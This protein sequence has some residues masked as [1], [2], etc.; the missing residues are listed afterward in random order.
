MISGIGR[1]GGPGGPRTPPICQTDYFFISKRN[2]GLLL[3]QKYLKNIHRF[4]LIVFDYLLLSI[5]FIILSY[6]LHIIRLLILAAVCTCCFMSGKEDKRWPRFMEMLL[7]VFCLLMGGDYGNRVSHTTNRSFVKVVF[8]N[9]WGQCP[10]TPLLARFTR[11]K[12][13]P[14]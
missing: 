4:Y 14:I 7:S 1:G 12:P 6:L 9:R 2:R 8:L 5:M 13:P 11:S 3:F 10:Q